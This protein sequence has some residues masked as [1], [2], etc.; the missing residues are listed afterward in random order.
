MA[1]TDFPFLEKNTTELL[2]ELFDGLYIIDRQRRILFWNSGAERITG[3]PRQQLVGLACDQGPL[4]HE[5]EDE[6]RLCEGKCP[7]VRVI[8]SGR[9]L[10]AVVYVHRANQEKL[11]VET[12][13]RPLHNAQGEIIGA[14][15]VF[16]DVSHW[17]ELERLYQEKEHM[18]GLLA[19]DIR[20]PLSV[21]LTW[22]RVLSHD[23]DPQTK[24]KADIIVRR[25][26]FATALVNQ[27]LDG[28]AIENGMVALDIQE[29]EVEA[30]V[31]ECLANYTAPADAKRIRL[32]LD[33][34]SP[35]L[36]LCMD[37]T[38]FEE[39]M[40]NLISNAIQY[41]Y[42]DSD[43]RITVAE[44]DRGVEIR[45]SDQGVG[46]KPKEQDQ[47]FKPFG[48]ASNRPTAGESSFGLGLYIVKKILDLFAGS[49]TVDS[50][51]KR[52]TTFIVR[53]PYAG[54][55]IPR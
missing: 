48:K 50:E 22:A 46:I 11:P 21:I 2:D 26:K 28:Q 6:C 14:I 40:N 12:H 25:A 33:L 13:I 37:P 31:K 49:I 8:E 39:I 27:L 15:E 1:A 47:I 16:R 24:E 19:H 7:A 44:Y 30:A 17:K 18:L 52:G 34:Q 32:L 53:L 9:P 4:R 36:K 41:S 55:P 51:P 5:D 35:G 43:V 23:G 29:L 10:V 54:C 42:P 45:V 20:T 3:Y 38:R